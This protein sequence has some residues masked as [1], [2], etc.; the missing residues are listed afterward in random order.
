MFDALF[1]AYEASVLKRPLLSLL[2]VLAVVGAL[3]ANLGNLKLDASSDSL[4]LEGDKDLQYF[5]EI[6]KR[7]HTEDFLIVTY[8]PNEDLYSDAAL[9]RL[10]K[11]RGDLAAMPGVASVMSILDVPLLQSPQVSLSAVT[12]GNLKTL[13]DDVDRK[14]VAAEFHSSPIYKSL[15][16]SEDAKTTALQVNL[17]RDDRYIEL[18]ERRD[19]LRARDRRGELSLVEQ[20]M[21]A[22]AE[23][24][25]Q[26][27]VAMAQ[28]RQSDLVALAREIIDGYRDHGTL[29]LGGLPMIASDMISFVESDLVVF[30]TGIIVFIIVLLV[31]IFRSMVW[32]LLP[33]STCLLAVAFMLGLLA[34]LDWRMTVIS[35]N[36]VAL[37]LIITLAVSIHLVVRY[38]ELAAKAGDDVTQLTLVSETVRLMAQ[39]C[40]YTTL[41]TLVAF[42]SLVISGIRPV[43]DFGWMM[44]IG[45][46]VAFIMSFAV[47]PAVLML[48]KP[49]RQADSDNSQSFT[50]YFA[51]ATENRGGVIILV[52]LGVLVA[53]LIGVSQLKVE[54]RFIDY[55]KDTTEI[56]QGMET[57]DAELGGTISLDIIL[58]APQ[59]EAVPA[60]VAA[61]DDFA[62]AGDDF[63]DDFAVAGDDFADDFEDDFASPVGAPVNDS[64]W[65]SVAG[66]ARVKEVHDYMDGLEETGKVL[67]LATLYE[68]MGLIL[69]GSVD[70]LQLKLARSA[71]PE[72]INTILVDPYFSADPDEARIS[73]RVK[74]TSRTLQRDQL[75]K[76]VRAHLVNEL[77]FKDENVHLTGMLVLYNNML[78]SLF[79]SQILTI[80]AVFAAIMLMFMVLFRSLWLAVIA[81]TP[82]MLAA[83]AVLGSMGL[84]GIPLDMMTITIAAI[85][86]GIGVDHAIHYVHRFQAEF[87]VDRNY[88]R[89]VYR[90]HGSIGK[91]MYYTSVIII[92]GFSIL[93]LSNFNPSIYFGLLT[94]GAMLA[95]LLGSL[96]LLPRMIVIFKPLGPGQ[97]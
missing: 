2:L 1:K 53:S 75:L 15:L 80:S 52:A 23:Q 45:V 71:L 72:E 47:L 85:T 81:I 6:G 8:R 12:S 57:I 7:Y 19:E 49:L 13:R 27:H 73:L 11:L 78:Q 41:T 66:M 24:E 4:V 22:V 67:S 29:F 92:F 50:R 32:T 36:F 55:F 51:A 58:D 28:Q 64:Y 5:R 97:Q 91:A 94:A 33:L 76:E 96:L 17:Q 84:L 65:F 59:P 14:L 48:M 60:S 3:V 20:D 9:E 46:M 56:Y 82:N 90:C 16:V 63:E 31:V 93:A 83:G 69:G 86:V 87:P 18:L 79:S 62:P 21:Y 34:T 26:D 88:I 68:L 40:L 38:R 61:N 42:M 39:P 37:L 44:T 43:I 77:G 95:A 30:G 89:T 10:E 25:F 74:E 35:S 54:N 70:D